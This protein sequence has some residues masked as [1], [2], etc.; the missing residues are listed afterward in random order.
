[1]QLKISDYFFCNR[2]FLPSDGRS[3][4]G[5]AMYFDNLLVFVGEKKM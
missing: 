4:S 3:D 1:M 2:A 5:A